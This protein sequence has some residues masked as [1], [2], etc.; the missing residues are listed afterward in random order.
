[1]DTAESA[2]LAAMGLAPPLA[3]GGGEE[4]CPVY[5]V[6]EPGQQ[7]AVGVGPPP[8]DEVSAFVLGWRF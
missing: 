5:R 1:M 2:H 3:G 4:A 6:D 7:Q 8:S